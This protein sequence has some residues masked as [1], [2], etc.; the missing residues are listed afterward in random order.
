[1]WTGQPDPRRVLGHSDLFVIPFSLMWGGFAVFWEV[2][3]LISGGFFFM[4]WGIPFVLMGQ[5]LIWGRLLHK[6]WQRQR[7][8][9]AVTDRRVL[10]LRWRSI[11]SA[12]IAR[13]PPFTLKR[14]HRDGSGTIDFGLE[15]SPWAGGNAWGDAIPGFFGAAP[16]LA[17]FDV[18]NVRRAYELIVGSAGTQPPAV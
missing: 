12:M 10:V 9:C 7:T 2:S 17:F 1:M 18:P 5:Y 13:L 4:I 14:V 8:I 3:V 6:R 16:P 11:Q 15:R